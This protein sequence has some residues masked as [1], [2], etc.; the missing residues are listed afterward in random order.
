[1]AKTLWTVNSKEREIIDL[2]LQGKTKP[3]TNYY[4]RGPNTGTWWFPGAKHPQWHRGYALIHKYW[5]TQKRPKSF[6]YDYKLYTTVLEHDESEQFP[7]KPAFHQNHGFLFLDWQEELHNNRTPIRTIIG[8]FGSGKTLS[9]AV[10]LLIFAAIL[11]G[12]RGFGLAP[13]ATQANEILKL[14]YQVMSGTL[15]E[16]RFLLGYTRGPNAYMKIGNSLVGSENVIECKPILKKEESL[17]TL[18]GD[19]AIVDQ[20]ERFDDLEGVIREVGTRFRGRVLETGRGRIGTLTLVA[21][22]A[23][24]DSLW[25]IYEKAEEDAAHYYSV[26]PSTYSNPYL[27]DEDLDRYEMQVGDS[28]EDKR[29]YLL[30]GRPLGDGREFSRD[31]L[32]RMQMPELDEEMNAGI[33]ANLAGFSKQELRHV[34]IHEWLL[35]YKEGH[36]YLVVSDPGT[37]N[38]PYRNAFGV[39]V[40]DITQFP[41]EPATMAGFVWGFG[42][43]DIQNWANKHAELTWKY[44]AVASNGFDA[45]GFQSGYDSWMQ[46]LNNLLSEKINLGGNNKADCLNSAKMLCSAGRIKLPV[47]ITGLYNQLQRYELPEPPKLK[48]DLVMVLIMACWWLKRLYYWQLP[49]DPIP[50]QERGY[51][52]EDRYH[53]PMESRFGGHPR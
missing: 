18:S 50:F 11:P 44:H 23:Y 27:T 2:A 53:R 17:R 14:A 12:F 22:S 3:F 34:G 29:V 7:N 46:I 51:Y 39:I 26:S 25:R 42:K 16:E 32:K 24:N 30:G 6:E 1:M 10:S 21:N 8:G 28:D 15:Y 4:L 20:A 38:P 47:G 9:Q 33:T 40:F 49:S 19:M 52:G 13:E 45:T 5:I 41:I 31:V 36:K 43:G 35:P 48:Q 37:D